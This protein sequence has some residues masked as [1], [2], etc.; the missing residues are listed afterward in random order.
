MVGV[1]GRAP[2]RAI[3]S[4]SEL[5]G[6]FPGGFR[7]LFASVYYKVIHTFISAMFVPRSTSS[8]VM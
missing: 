7:R 8:W 2:R 3:A 5:G 6:G 1:G 4:S